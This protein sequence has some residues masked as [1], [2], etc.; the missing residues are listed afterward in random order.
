ML[1]VASRDGFDARKTGRGERFHAAA[2]PSGASLIPEAFIVSP[3]QARDK[4][5]DKR[6]DIWAFGVVL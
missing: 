3:E 6:A 2:S 1:D 4:A 5:A